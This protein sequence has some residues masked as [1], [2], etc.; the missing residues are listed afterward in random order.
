MT[1]GDAVLRRRT[2]GQSLKGAARSLVELGGDVGHHVAV[3]KLQKPLEGEGAGGP[4]A[5]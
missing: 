5:R 1:G 4:P 3:R 2:G